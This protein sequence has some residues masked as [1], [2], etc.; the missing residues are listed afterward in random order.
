MTQPNSNTPDETFI[1]TYR[2]GQ[3]ILR[4]DAFMALS[5][6]QLNPNGFEKINNAD[7]MLAVKNATVPPSDADALTDIELLALAQ[8]VTL[9]LRSLGN[10]SAP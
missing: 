4:V 10:V 3:K 7:L 9:H 2:V 8:R 5:A 1:Q 6:L